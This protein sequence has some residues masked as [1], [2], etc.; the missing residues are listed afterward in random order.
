MIELTELERARIDASRDN[1]S[2]TPEQ[3]LR[4]ALD[5][6]RRGIIHGDAAIVLIIK[7]AHGTSGGTR[8]V[9]RSNISRIDEVAMLEYSKA[10]ALQDWME[11]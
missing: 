7:K 4:L 8:N 10:R 11:S 5:D 2:V 9:Y 1:T 3:V 6:L